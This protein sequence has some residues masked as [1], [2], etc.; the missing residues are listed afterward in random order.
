MKCFGNNVYG[1]L[2][3]GDSLDRGDDR[4]E[5]G[6]NLP[7]VDLE[8]IISV[9]I[10][11][12]HTCALLENS[13]IKCFGSNEYGQL[14]L[15]DRLNRGDNEN[16]MSI[17]LPFA[18]LGTD[19]PVISIAAGGYHNCVLFDNHRIKCFG[20]N[21][22]GQLGLEDTNNREDNM[23]EMGTMLE[24]VDVG[25]DML[26]VAVGAGSRHTCVLLDNYKMK[27]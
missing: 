22:F 18:D 4:N 24:Y 2:G 8:G 25:N 27:F 9:R 13:K 1:Q 15:G 20:W 5:M 11:L 14:G 12:Y 21:M 10:G 17:N 16:E 3:L 6:Y 23:G 26:V 19:R 7:F